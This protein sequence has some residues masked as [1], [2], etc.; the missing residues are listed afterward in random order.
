MPEVEAAERTTVGVKLLVTH[1][2]RR[3]GTEVPRESVVRC[4]QL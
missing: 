4:F 3:R 1:G 2:K